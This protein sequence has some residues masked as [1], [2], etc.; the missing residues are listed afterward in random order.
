MMY[1][2]L[3]FL[4][5]AASRR[6]GVG[7]YFVNSVE[8]IPWERLHRALSGASR[9]L[10]V[11]MDSEARMPA[12]N[13]SGQSILKCAGRTKGIEMPK[14]LLE[15]RRRILCLAWRLTTAAC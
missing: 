13:H 6:R 15:Q 2:G 5:Y 3:I 10:S 4:H 1:E 14:L 9:C 11:T 8:G 7:E 12:D